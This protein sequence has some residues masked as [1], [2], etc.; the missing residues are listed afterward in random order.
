MKILIYGAGVLGSYLAHALVRG[1]NDVTML[2]RGR[3]VEELTSDG[4]VIRH[5]LQRKTTV[6][7]VQ[8]IRTLR[9]DDVYDL[10]FVVMQY[11][12]LQAILPALADNQSRHL[13]LVGNNADA[14]VIQQYLKENS[15]VEKQV[16][17]GF[18]YS[19]GRRENGRIIC[20]RG[21][22][23]MDIGGL[24]GDLSW[25]PLLEKAFEKVNYKL[26]FSETIDAWLKSH[27]V[28]V[29]VLCYATYAGDGDLRK[30]VGDKKLLNQ[31][32]GALD[33]GYQVLETL[34]YPI[35]PTSQAHFVRT[36]RR[37]VSLLLKIYVVTPFTRLVDPMSQVDETFALNH[38]F[39]D[40]KQ[41]AHISTPNWDVLEN[42]LPRVPA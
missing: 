36:R 18:Q 3:R 25:R 17:F 35:T 13:V 10:L 16:A 9:S 12:D 41:K 23:R 14:S 4:I 34:G 1:G 8:V 21:G 5:Y 26:V 6:D 31:I 38:A 19:G 28:P 33:E 39:N 40:L 24:D 27:I 30:A 15:P 22:G 32:M 42:Y 29:L 7:K 2:A 37:M 11:S 20:V